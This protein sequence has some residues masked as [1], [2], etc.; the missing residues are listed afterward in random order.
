[1]MNEMNF[2]NVPAAA[3]VPPNSI[4][5]LSARFMCP[6]CLAA[7]APYGAVE[8]PAKIFLLTTVAFFRHKVLHAVTGVRNAQGLLA[9]P[10]IATIVDSFSWR[11]CMPSDHIEV[12]Q[13]LWDAW[14]SYC[15][16]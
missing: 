16:S 3:S 7:D 1:M 10:Q 13:R 9:S 14:L 8:G 15:R 12:E 2:R 11:S 6:F 5:P 4:C